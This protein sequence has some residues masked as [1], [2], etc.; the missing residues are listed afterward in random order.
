METNELAKI[1]IVDDE[2]L[3]CEL[4][5]AMASSLGIETKS[6]TRSLKVMDEVRNTFYNLVLLDV[7]M[8]ERSGFEL[9]PDIQKASSDTKIIIITGRADK[10]VATKALRLG[11]FDFLEKPIN[12]ELLSY[13][14]NRALHIQETELEYK[15]TRETLEYSQ[16]D[17]LDHKEKLEDLNRRLIQTNQAL[18]VLAQNIAREREETEKRIVLKTRSLIIPIIERLQHDKNLKRYEAELIMLVKHLEDLTS[19]LAADTKIATSLSFSE[20]RIASL[21]KNGLT[22]EDIAKHLHIS[23]S[24]IKTHRKNIRRKL[25][26]NNRQQNLRNYLDSK[27]EK[28]SGP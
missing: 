18:T 12:M 11:A 20:L 13:S 26:I 1:L 24:T 17:L 8:P 15:K 23:P 4:L 3:V 14:V 21:I 2:P 28:R 6:I 5:E 10:E 16:V 22:T 25:G 7:F 27:L 9:I 19:G